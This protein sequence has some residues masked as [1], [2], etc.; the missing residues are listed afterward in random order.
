MLPRG[1]VY[2]KRSDLTDHVRPASSA[3]QRTST[4]ITNVKL[5]TCTSPAQVDTEAFER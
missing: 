4:L 2:T 3:L 1:S 5:K